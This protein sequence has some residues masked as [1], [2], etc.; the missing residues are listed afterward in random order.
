MAKEN[1]SQR[2]VTV[3]KTL[4]TIACLVTTTLALVSPVVGEKPDKE[5]NPN[6]FP[7]GHHYNWNIIGKKANF[8]CPEQATDDFG[9][10]VYGNVVFVPEHGDNIEILMQSGKGKRAANITELQVIDWCTKTFDGDAAVLQLPKNDQG[11]RVYARA[12]AKPTDN[13]YLKIVPSL[14]AVVDESGNDLIY[15]GLVTSNG[16]TSPYGS[17]TRKKGKSKATNITGLFEW[18]GEVCYLNEDYCNPWDECSQTALCCT[19]VEP[20]GVF[21]SCEV[22]GDACAMETIEVAAFCKTYDSEWVFNIG[23][24]VTVLWATD[25]HGVKLLQVRFYPNE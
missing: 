4:R 14:E 16:F 2:R 11:Y 13:P 10:L 24:F 8:T 19:A 18:S 22:K 20:D 3:Q 21:E 23:D 12:L 1:I 25:N 17:Y 5:V 7:S 9:N 6:G 15:L